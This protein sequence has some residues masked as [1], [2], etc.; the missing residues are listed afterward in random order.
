MSFIAETEVRLHQL[1]K[2]PD[3]LDNLRQKIALWGLAQDFIQPKIFLGG[4]YHAGS[5]KNL[6]VL[7]DLRDG[8]QQQT[9]G[10][11]DICI[12]LDYPHR[13][14]SYP[15]LQ[16]MAFLNR[17]QFRSNDTKSI[18]TELR[19]VIGED[20]GKFFLL[21][22]TLEGDISG[23]VIRRHRMDSERI[24]NKWREKSQ[25]KGLDEPMFDRYSVVDLAASAEHDLRVRITPSESHYLARVKDIPA[26]PVNVLR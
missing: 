6:W 7:A 17:A 24:R 22:D 26:L 19:S 10:A 5:G 21:P 3:C 25:W 15:G 8:R 2:T 4:L 13:S 1:S 11:G 9:L 12:L 23:I 14:G 20:T 16:E 18:S